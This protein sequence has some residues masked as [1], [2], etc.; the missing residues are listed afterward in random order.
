MP[1]V[2]RIQKKL[3]NLGGGFFFLFFLSIWIM[4]RGLLGFKNFKYNF[5]E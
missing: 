4:M 5:K 2:F 1:K 3:K